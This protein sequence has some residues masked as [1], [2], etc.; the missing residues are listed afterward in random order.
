[1]SE[2][3]APDVAAIAGRLSEAQRRAVMRAEQNGHLGRYFVSW[4]HANGTTLRALRR[5]GLGVPCWSGVMLTALGLALR[6]H[7]ME[8]NDV[9]G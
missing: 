3:N 4:W 6:N 1:M 8:K 5:K 9:Q 7:L 2:D